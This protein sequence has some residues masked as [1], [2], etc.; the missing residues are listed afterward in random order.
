MAIV[1]NWNVLQM[2]AYPEYEGET[3]VVF[4]VNWGLTG[5]DGEYIGYVYGSTPVTLNPE[6]PFT[7]YAD[8]TLDQV[9]GWVQDALGAEQVS[10]YEEN[11]ANQIADKKNPPVVNPPLPWLPQQ[12]A[13]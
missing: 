4:L 8:L 7:P 1:Y 6:S 10:A 9:V 5:V 12:T 3:D 13:V 11:V 2:S